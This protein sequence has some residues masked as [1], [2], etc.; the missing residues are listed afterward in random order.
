MDICDTHDHTTGDHMHTDITI[1]NTEDHIRIT[2][3]NCQ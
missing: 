1:F 2:V 3:L